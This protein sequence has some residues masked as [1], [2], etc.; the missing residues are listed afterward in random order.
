MRFVAS[1]TLAALAG[2]ACAENVGDGRVYAF[3]NSVKIISSVPNGTTPPTAEVRLGY[4]NLG[5]KYAD[6]KVQITGGKPIGTPRTI[7]FLAFPRR[8]DFTLQSQLVFKYDSRSNLIFKT[9]YLAAD[10]NGV[11]T[12]FKPGSTSTVP[13]IAAKPVPYLSSLVLVN[14]GNVNER[15][16]AT[17]GY[18]APWHPGI[19]FPITS[20]INHVGTGTGAKWELGK[21]PPKVFTAGTHATEFTL[22]FPISG[23]V[24]WN[25]GGITVVANQA[26]YESQFAPASGG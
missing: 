25:I 6:A 22:S 9:E 4:N 5:T 10:A 18:K 24:S 3:I 20:V 26:V 12:W 8:V 11:P 21:Q 19:T 16:A 17:F 13:G 14:P 15:L 1:L 2:T 7:P 23:E